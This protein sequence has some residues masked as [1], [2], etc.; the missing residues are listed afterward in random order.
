MSM[1]RKL[2]LWF[3]NYAP[4]T[5]NWITLFQFA[6]IINHK[7]CH[8][9]QTSDQ[10]K[11]A[12]LPNRQLN[13][14]DLRHIYFTYM[15]DNLLITLIETYHQELYL[16]HN[17][18]NV[19][20]DSNSNRTKTETQTDESTSTPNQL[21]KTDTI[22]SLP[23]IQLIDSTIY[24]INQLK[25]LPQCLPQKIW[26]QTGIKIKKWMKLISLQTN[27]QIPFTYLDFIPITNDSEYLQYLNQWITHQPNQTIDLTHNYSIT[28]NVLNQ[29]PI[30]QQIT[31]IRLNQNFQI[32]DFNWLNHLPNLQLFDCTNCQQLEQKHMIQIS[33][34]APKLQVVNLHY[35]CRINIRILIPLFKLE[36][37]NKLSVEDPYFRCQEGIYQLYI[38]PQEWAGLCSSSLEKLAINSTNMTIDIIDYLNRA[39]PNLQQ[40]I[41]DQSLFPTIG[42]CASNGHE[43]EHLNFHSWQD[44]NKGLT[45]TKKV[46][47]HNLLRD[48]YSDQPFSESMLRKIAEN[49]AKKNEV[50][51]TP[52]D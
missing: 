6:Q 26:K 50:E 31:Q 17:T 1:N 48:N 14:N 49:R 40:M 2:K 7:N 15:T 21:V 39:C 24:L 16:I 25:H 10:N 30:Y 36:H 32:Q 35:C 18:L 23:E 46:T 34:C 41:V 12:Y 8:W 42:Q 45:Y 13:P 3:N 5:N 4:Q 22:M 47:F 33:Q 44:P 28:T 11:I 37:L 38:L 43:K 52:L 19:F 9:M 51:Q 27:E 20:D 29:I